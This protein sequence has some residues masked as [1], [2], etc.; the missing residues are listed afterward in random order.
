MLKMRPS[1]PS[2]LSSLPAYTQPSARLGLERAPFMNNK[3]RK[4][5]GRFPTHT[6]PH[7]H[8]PQI[9]AQERAYREPGER[10]KYPSSGWGSHHVT[11]LTVLVLSWYPQYSHMECSGKVQFC[12]HLGDTFPLWGLQ[13]DRVIH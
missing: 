1:S 9:P 13:Y 10:A 5:S 12:K 4:F 11:G 7:T 3:P 6:H 8:T 2:C